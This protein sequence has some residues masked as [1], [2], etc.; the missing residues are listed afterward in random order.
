MCPSPTLTVQDTASLQGFNTFQVPARA[1]HLAT[2][3]SEAELLALL[4]EPRYQDQPRLVL[5]GGSNILFTGDFPGLVL[6]IA[7]MGIKVSSGS[8]QVD[9]VRVGAGENW[10]AFVRWSL[11]QGYEGIENLILIPGSVGAAPMQNIGAYGVEVAEFIH[12]VRVLDCRTGQFS[13]LDREACDFAYRDSLFKRRRGRYIITEVIF[14]LPRECPRITHYAGVA[15]HL[16]QAGI[17]Q[18]SAWQ[19]AEAVAH[20]RRQKLP[21]PSEQGNA[22]SFFK[23]PVV[24]ARQAAQLQR[25]HPELRVFPAEEGVK[26]S[27]AWLIEACG[28]KGH[29]QGPVGISERHALVLINRGGASGEALWAMAREVQEAVASRF[30]VHLEPEPLVV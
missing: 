29:F 2:V 20:L 3:A 6:K 5:G 1:R 24:D 23:N 9:E 28:F 13:E 16:D 10:D 11:D 19:V 8:G 25:R 7:L 12:G 27:A 26:L 17:S 21:D 15:E 18:P 30:G 22:G 4:N 14:H